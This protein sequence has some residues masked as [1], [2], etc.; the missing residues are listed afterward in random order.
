MVDPEINESKPD[1]NSPR[2]LRQFALI[3]LVIFTAL[4]ASE[5]IWY[6]RQGPALIF[7]GLAALLGVAGLV[8]P[9]G[10]RPVFVSAMIVTM[11]VGWVMS[12]VLLAI[13]YFLFFTPLGLLF[14]LIGRDALNRHSISKQTSYWEPK[15][16]PTDIRSYLRQS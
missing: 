15:R 7:A 8:W 14:K 13:L 12:R 9:Q 16:R 1:W 11:P 3:C 6:K 5:Y 10:I 2:T 4:A